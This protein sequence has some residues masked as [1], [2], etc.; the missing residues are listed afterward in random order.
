MSI[1]KVVVLGA[2]AATGV[3]G[4]AVF[5]WHATQ[6]RAALH[7]TYGHFQSLV[8]AHADL[9]ALFV[10]E[11]MQN[12]HRTNVFAEGVWALLSAILAGIGLHGLCVTRRA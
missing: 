11:A 10:A 4:A 6:D 7:V 2:I 1:V 3:F 8:S 9:R 5:G 12:L